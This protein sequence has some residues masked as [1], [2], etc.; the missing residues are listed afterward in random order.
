MIDPYGFVE[1][2]DLFLKGPQPLALG[3]II[4]PKTGKFKKSDKAKR[5]RREKKKAEV[6][7]RAAHVEVMDLTGDDEFN[8]K[9]VGHM[10]RPYTQLPIRTPS[11]ARSDNSPDKRNASSGINAEY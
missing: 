6:I 5:H 9:L 7:A 3:D 4:N 8:S 2:A 10:N 1:P 11:R